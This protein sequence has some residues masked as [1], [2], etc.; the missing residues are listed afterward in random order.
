MTDAPKGFPLH[1]PAG[2][3][4]TVAIARKFGQFRRNG[5]WLTVAL[6]ADRLEA[7]LGRLGAV[8]PIISTNVE[9]TLSGRPRAGQGA[10]NDPG[11]CVYFSLKGKPYAMAC[12]RYQHVEDN[13]AAIAAHIDAVRKIER[14]GVSTAAETLQSFEALPAPKRAH[15]ILGVQPNASPNEVRRAWRD[16]I[17]TAHPDV[18]GTHARAAEI[19]AARDEMLRG[20]ACP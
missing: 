15:E 1:W 2:K 19:N 5:S 13:L 4:R 16:L 12:D 6:A 10:P 11:A 14:H 9:M 20:A 18:A 17:A 3:P 8:Y 7:E